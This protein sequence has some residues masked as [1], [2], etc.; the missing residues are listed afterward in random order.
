MASSEEP[1]HQGVCPRILRGHEVMD[2]VA[3]EAQKAIRAGTIGAVRRSNLDMNLHGA[4]DAVHS[5]TNGI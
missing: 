2:E 1:L 3:Q 4:R 5:L